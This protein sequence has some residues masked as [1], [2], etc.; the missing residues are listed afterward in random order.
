[1]NA[2]CVVEECEQANWFLGAAGVCNAT[3]NRC[4]CPPGFSGRFIL[5][6][7]ETCHI[8]HLLKLVFS[9]FGLGIN[10][11]AMGLL[12]AFFGKVMNDIKSLS[13]RA[14]IV[15]V[16]F[17]SKRGQG[18]RLIRGFTKTLRG[19]SMSAMTEEKRRSTIMRR[20]L[21]VLF[22]LA[23]FCVYLLFNLPRMIIVFGDLDIFAEELHGPWMLIYVTG[24]V[25]FVLGMSGFLYS[26]YKSLP[27]VTYLAKTAGI[28]SILA[29]NPSCKCRPYVE[30]QYAQSS[31]MPFRVVI[32]YVMHVNSIIL[33][34]IF[35]AIGFIYTADAV[36]GFRENVTT[37]L[38][39][40]YALMSTDLYIVYCMIYYLTVKLFRQV[41]PMRTSKPLSSKSQTCRFSERTKVG[42]RCQ[43]SKWQCSA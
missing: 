33:V 2:S 15:P 23:C 19:G 29:Q 40:F 6:P 1:M 28:N 3:T 4:E 8:S 18:M 22:V 5:N 42:C 14:S 41:S 27:N 31:F 38:T 20:K 12:F 24:D 9:S 7:S 36:Q 11:I 26:F 32:Y 10:V 37:V 16:S 30:I 34:L 39:I 25:G 35:Y 13:S 21:S 17:E 43:K